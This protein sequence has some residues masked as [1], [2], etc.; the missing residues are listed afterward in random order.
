MPE[1]P[2]VETIK[3]QLEKRVKGKKFIKIEILFKKPLGKV[4]VKN[5]EKIAKDVRIKNVKRRAKLLLINLSNGNT[6]AIHLKLTGR[7]LFVPQK[8]KPTKHTHIVFHLSS[9]G[10]IFYEDIRK[11]GFIKVVPTEDLDTFIKQQSFGPEPLLKN[12]NL[13]VFKD[14]LSKKSKSKIKPLLMDPK[15]IAGIGNIYATEIC[16]CAGVLPTRKIE[17]LQDREIKKLH[18]CIKKILR[19]AIKKKGSS[20]DTY[21]DFYGKKGK[22][23]MILY[24]Y[25]R[26]GEKC[27]KC[28]EKLKEMKL[29]GRGTV[30]CPKCQK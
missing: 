16:F 14:L 7:L 19:T 8:T 25:G 15:F 29:G 17:T 23:D 5:F 6:L 11:F 10:K 13:K 28:G 24:A 20:V 21:R 1:L 12:F 3:Q 4:S 22:N 27:E 18:E 26:K 2:E 30:Y 9:G